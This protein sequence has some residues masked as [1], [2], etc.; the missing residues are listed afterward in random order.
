MQINFR[1][2]AVLEIRCCLFGR[3]EGLF[4]GIVWSRGRVLLK[5]RGVVIVL[6]VG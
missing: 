4:R 6:V 3:R 1:Y 2:S 5:G